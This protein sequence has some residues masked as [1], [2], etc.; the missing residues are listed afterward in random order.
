[1]GGGRLHRHAHLHVLGARLPRF[2]RRAHVHE[3]RQAGARRGRSAR[4]L[5]QWAPVHA[6]PEPGRGR[7]LRRPP[8][9]PAAARRRARREQM[10]AHHL[11]GGA[12]RDSRLDTREPRRG[13]LRPRVDL[14]EP[15]DGAQHLVL[16]AVSG[17]GVPRHAE[18]RRHRLLGVLVLPA[19]HVRHGRR[20]RRLPHRGRLRGPCRPLREPRM[21]ASRRRGGVGLRA[22]ALERGRLPGP[23]AERVPADGHGVHLHRPAAH[24][25]GSPRGV[26]AAPAPGHRPGARARVAQRDHD[27][28]PDRPRVR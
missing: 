7:E 15:R 1:M 27:R 20:H 23:L 21:G 9:V 25:V 18:H 2:V 17:R 10:G 4:P 13:G 19:A 22:A 3:G 26:L 6:L 14:R 8:Q 28:G 16:G 11:G 12:R 24:L 5:R